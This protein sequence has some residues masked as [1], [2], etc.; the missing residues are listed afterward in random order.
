MRRDERACRAVQEMHLVARAAFVAGNHRYSLAFGYF[1]CRS[2]VRTRSWIP[3][4][5]VVVLKAH[6]RGQLRF[7]RF[8]GPLSEVVEAAKCQEAP[9]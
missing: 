4:A 5:Y 9:H 3:Q 2:H 1:H 7:C 6:S 8:A